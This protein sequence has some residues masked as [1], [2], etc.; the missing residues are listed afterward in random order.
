MV[1]PNIQ[2]HLSN[3]KPRLIGC[4]LPY[5]ANY[6]SDEEVYSTR[7]SIDHNQVSARTKSEF[8]FRQPQN[9]EKH[10]SCTECLNLKHEIK[11]QQKSNLNEKSKLADS[12]R[13]LKQLRNLLDI[14]GNRLKEEE[15]VLKAEKEMLS[16]QKVEFSAFM[17]KKKQ[18][19]REKLQIL[20]DEKKVAATKNKE[21][22]SIMFE[23]KN[24]KKILKSSIKAKISE[25]FSLRETI[26]LRSQQ[27]LVA[28]EEN[29]RIRC[30]EKEKLFKKIEEE[31]M[32]RKKNF[33]L[34]ENKLSEK[35]KILEQR[36]EKLKWFELESNDFLNKNRD[37]EKVSEEKEAEIQK[38]KGE[39]QEKNLILDEIQK[40]NLGDKKTEGF[41]DLNCEKEANFRQRVGLSKEKL[42]EFEKLM[43]ELQRRLGK[44]SK[45]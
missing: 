20:S 42:N 36:E 12:E 33:D 15:T 19:I 25:K 11:N 27:D 26:I 30:L 41:E 32:E 7:S 38:L 23:Y 17:Q 34:T 16:S 1:E 37:Y 6:N 21:L 35:Q 45:K 8:T 13:Y 31:L 43:K 2:L 28:K 14:K 39:L 44:V 40:N 9:P 5:T 18:A 24:N 22:D 10:Q 29:L 4:L 3:R